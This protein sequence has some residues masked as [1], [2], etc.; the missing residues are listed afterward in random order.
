MPVKWRAAER[1]E[2]KAGK[3]AP[4]RAARSSKHAPLPAPVPNPSNGLTF[5]ECA[6]KVIGLRRSE[7][8]SSDRH[9][10]QWT[11]SLTLHAYPK[12]GDLPVSSVT[13][14]D[15]LDLLTPIWNE[16]AETATRVKQRAAVVFDWAIA[17]GLRTDN[18]ATAVGRALPRRPRLKQHHPALPYWDVPELI[19]RVRES[20]TRELTRLAL[21]F[22]ILTAARAGEVRGATWAE[23]D[24]DSA[25]WE[26]PAERMKM[27]RGH[28]VPLSDAAIDLLL[29]AKYFQTAPDGLVFPGTK[30][31]PLSNMAFTMLLR[32]L[33]VDATTH[34]F[35]S[36][37]SKTLP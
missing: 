37:V 24:L 28:R 15:V 6:D 5:R 23:I 9:A 13:S 8:E 3:Q 22:V 2:L 16:K 27:R 21:E 14:A 19:S 26:I 35:R 20:T 11:E 30:G 7:L 4:R 1:E 25:V 36:S 29:A 18:P 33:G 31:K 34:G 32:R 17:A 12:I 10:T